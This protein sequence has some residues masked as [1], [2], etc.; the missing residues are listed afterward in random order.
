M[1]TGTVLTKR[2]VITQQISICEWC[3]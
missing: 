2:T 1:F 3:C